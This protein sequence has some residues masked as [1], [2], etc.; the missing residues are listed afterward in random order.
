MIVI[1]KITKG[2]FVK[3]KKNTKEHETKN[4]IIK[5]AKIYMDNNINISNRINELI[6]ELSE[7]REDER[8]TQNQILQVIS[9]V[10]TI[11][12]ILFSASYLT[13]ERAEE[14]IVI[15]PN[16]N[17]K[18]ATYINRF[19][20]IINENVTYERVLF[21]LSLLVFCTAFS[22]IIVLGMD[23]VLRYYY[24]QN[25]ED[26]LYNLIDNTRDNDGRGSFLH[27]NAYSA[28]II[29]KNIKHITSTHTAL[30]Y[31]CYSVAICCII[32]FSMGMVISLFLE[33][34]QRKWFDYM[35]ICIA[36]IGMIL[37]FFLFLR[38]SSD[39]KN[40][41]KLAW[42]TAHENQKIRLSGSKERIY[43]KAKS[44]K[45]ILIYLIYPKIQDLQKPALIVLGF[46]YGVILK[47]VSLGSFFNLLFVM[48]VFDFLAYQARYQINDIRGIEED[49]EAGCQNRLLT[50]DVNNPGHVIKISFIVAI[51]KMS[52]AITMATFGGGEVK[53]VLIASLGILL[54]STILYEIVRKKKITW[55]VFITVG[56]GYPLRFSVGFFT[57]VP[58][59]WR[60]L[61]NGQMICFVLAFWAYGSFSSILSWTNEVA[62][63]MQRF[64][65]DNNKFPESYTKKHFMDIQN[66]IE[67]RYIYAEKHPINEKVMPM[68]EKC[69]LQD[70][71]NIA[72]LLNLIF[73]FLTAF[74]GKIYWLLLCMEIGGGI[75][76]ILSIYVRRRKKLV[77]FGIG[78][79]CIIIKMLLGTLFYGVGIWFLL[80]SM[81]QL[82]MTATYFVLCYQPQI[83]MMSIREVLCVLMRWI[84][85]KMIG[86][87]AFTEIMN[88]KKNK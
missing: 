52:T 74:L 20:N 21:W 5:G 23:N 10:G 47:G 31:I 70:P 82:L 60:I 55:L 1:L 51:I 30:N 16:V 66:I 35:I 25:L 24:I 45:R 17:I 84:M 53:R 56:I 77:L 22:Y 69:R 36:I 81:S 13:P 68:R 80:L 32:L 87:N 58:F 33:I 48:F 41:A 18:E 9:I 67:E 63:R 59:E 86:E 78:W 73:L 7:C 79:S 3:V 40:M 54:I 62:G 14:A 42:D 43:G 26:R 39:T 4:T 76:F 12:G 49:K 34:T 83:K 8:N 64:K 85:I 6:S 27:W 44:F 88:N 11:L 28:P 46:I 15:F 29:T 37:T 75:A 38:S 19:C 50:D 65:G 57:M 61:L 72:F 2:Y 71:W